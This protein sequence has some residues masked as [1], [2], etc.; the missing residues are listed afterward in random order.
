MIMGGIAAAT[1]LAALAALRAD[2]SDET[3]RRTRDL[4]L[5]TGEPVL[6][7]FPRIANS[8]IAR[9]IRRLLTSAL[10]SFGIQ[11]A[12]AISVT[13]CAAWETR[14]VSDEAHAF[15]AGLLLDTAEQKRALSILIAS[16]M[17]GE[18]KTFTTMAVARAAA[19]SGRKV[20]VIDC[21]L[22]RATT[23]S[24]RSPRG[25]KG[26][27]E[28]LLGEIKPQEAVIETDAP[29]LE[30]IP[31]GS[32]RTNTVMLKEGMSH[33]ISWAGK[34]DLVLLDGPSGLLNDTGIIAR[35][36]E[37]VVWCVRWGHTHLAD[38]RTDLA[39]LHNRKIRL[40]GLALTMVDHRELR[41]Y[42]RNI[43]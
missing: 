18:G 5:L 9:A 34:Y 7:V 25:N 37:G 12:R 40:L 42:Q 29:G 19:A 23:A 2:A 41:Y 43:Q 39:H 32:T 33:L 28:I 6:A 15:C 1:G 14:T 8:T 4:E 20:L 11:P 30:I 27:S 17:P 31:A 16:A 21:D 13:G 26:L 36:A 35:Y 22:R 10:W 24:P 38:L 3:V